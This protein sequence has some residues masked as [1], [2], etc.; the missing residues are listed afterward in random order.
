MGY[1]EGCDFRLGINICKRDIPISEARRLL[2]EG[3]TALL[4][5]FISKNFKRFKARLEIKDGLAVFAFENPLPDKSAPAKQTK[6]TKTTRAK[7]SNKNS[8][9]E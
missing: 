4:D 5:G 9:T 2:A 3:K 1:T 6:T 8:P 7:K